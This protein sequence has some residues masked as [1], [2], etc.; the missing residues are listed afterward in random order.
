[1]AQCPR[2]QALFLWST[3]HTAAR[4]LARRQVWACCAASL[5][6]EGLQRL[7]P[8][9]GESPHTCPTL[10][11]LPFSERSGLL[12]HMLSLLS[13]FSSLKLGHLHRWSIELTFPGSCWT[14]LLLWDVSQGELVTSCPVL[15][16]CDSPRALA[17]LH[18]NDL[19]TRL[20]LPA[21]QP[22]CFLRTRTTMYSSVP[23][24]P[25]PEGE[26]EPCKHLINKRLT[27]GFTLSDK[28]IGSFCPN[29]ANLFSLRII[30]F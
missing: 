15:L 22:V 26:K 2:P 28:N 6:C 20:S 4:E 1:M 25:S 19:F 23:L 17:T 5:L 27:T 11:R 13:R 30:I 3:L 8:S 9:M 29:P 16:V 10:T 12:W 21:P 14:V 24:T 7:F 18:F